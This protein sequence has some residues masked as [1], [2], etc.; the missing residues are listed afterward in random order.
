MAKRKPKE[1]AKDQPVETVETPKAEVI[2]GEAT[3]FAPKSD[4]VISEN[5]IL[6]HVAETSG[7]DHKPEVE[8]LPVGDVTPPAEST[9]Q[10]SG[11][12]EKPEKRGRPRGSYK[13]K[14]QADGTLGEPQEVISTGINNMLLTPIGALLLDDYSK[15][16]IKPEQTKFLNMLLPVEEIKPSLGGYIAALAATTISNVLNAYISER[17]AKKKGVTPVMGPP[18]NEQILEFAM[19]MNE[20]QRRMFLDLVSKAD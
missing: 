7:I 10:A 4:G 12:T 15:A 2:T 17:M 20:E 5:E 16:L 3:D 18:S 14:V 19:R 8:K 6:D 13:K 11:E 1:T 9:A